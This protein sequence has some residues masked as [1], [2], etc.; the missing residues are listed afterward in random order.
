MSNKPVL[1]LQVNEETQLRLFEERHVED[2]F[3]LFESEKE[4][5][6]VLPPL[7]RLH[8]LLSTPGGRG[9]GCFY[10]PSSSPLR[11]VFPNLSRLRILLQG[12]VAIFANHVAGR[13]LP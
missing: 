5:K 8:F 11:F 2:Y 3:A 10:L 1:C 7:H 6:R 13:F 4:S 9:Q 12:L